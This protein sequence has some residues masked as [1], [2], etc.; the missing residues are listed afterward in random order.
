MDLTSQSPIREFPPNRKF[1][2]RQDPKIG[3]SV[4]KNL[5]KQ[6]KHE[7]GH[8]PPEEPPQERS[9]LFS[10]PTKSEDSAS[11]SE[12]AV[13]FIRNLPSWVKEKHLI[14]VSVIIAPIFM[15]VDHFPSTFDPDSC[16][17]GR[18]LF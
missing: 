1:V 5:K 11:T 10:L 16:P 6:K 7:H 2:V 14:V 3:H 15:Q 17:S 9:F 12:H 18:T 4:G 13:V 8:L